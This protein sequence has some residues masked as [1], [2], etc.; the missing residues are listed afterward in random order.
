MANYEVYLSASKNCVDGPSLNDFT[1][2]VLSALS[3]TKVE[4]FVSATQEFKDENASPYS[5]IGET[6]WYAQPGLLNGNVDPLI[7]EHVIQRLS[8]NVGEFDFAI[9]AGFPNSATK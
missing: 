2:L 4:D 5:I 3:E 9:Q 1:G 6:Y 8:Y 7:G